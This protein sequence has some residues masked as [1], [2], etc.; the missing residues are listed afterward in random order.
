LKSK[1]LV[2]STCLS[3]SVTVCVT[4]LAPGSEV[5]LFNQTL[6]FFDGQD[7]VRADVGDLINCAAGPADFYQ[8]NLRSVLESEVQPEIILRNVT[9]TTIDLFDLL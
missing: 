5:L 4:L 7:L 2:T 6:S 1:P 8:I 3:L 9:C